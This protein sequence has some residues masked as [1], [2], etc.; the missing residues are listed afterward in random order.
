MLIMRRPLNR[1]PLKM[2]I[3]LYCVRLHRRP[4]AR[5]KSEAELKQDE[6]DAEQIREAGTVLLQPLHM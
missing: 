1:G 3:I 4:G 2:P 6:Q 5:E